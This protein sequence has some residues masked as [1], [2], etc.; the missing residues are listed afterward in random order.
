MSDDTI[1]LW[2]RI[3]SKIAD[4]LVEPDAPSSA[5]SQPTS[6][7]PSSVVV[8]APA[9]N[10]D[11]AVFD[12]LRQTALSRKTVFSGLI[13]TAERLRSV[14][15]LDDIQR[16]KSAAAM[17]GNVTTE[18][19]VQAAAGHIGDI[20]S[21][22]RKFER[23]IASA[24]AARV[25]TVQSQVSTI[26]T[27][28]QSMQAEI[29]RMTTQIQQLVS[30]ATSLRAS[31]ADAEAE[32]LQTVTTFETTVARVEQYITTTRDAIVSALK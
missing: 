24:K 12:A 27:Q 21:E 10:V 1:P 19:I 4:T 6:P 22:R 28:A 14:P 11:Q 8:T 13:E 23:E 32:L 3:G 20:S 2:K 15:G 18:M 9:V 31:A 26:E 30:Q 7:Q 29:D 17:A 25:E 16:I 5:P